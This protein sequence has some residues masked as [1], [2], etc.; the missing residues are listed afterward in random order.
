MP[1][2][3]LEALSVGLSAEIERCVSAADIETFAAVTG[4]TNPV[5][6]DEA[7]AATTV[8][9]GRVAH[10]MLVVGYLSAI[11]GTQLPGPGAIYISQTLRFRRPVRVGDK[12]IARVEITALDAAR[13]RATLATTCRVADRIVVDGEAVVMVAKRPTT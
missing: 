11:L 3:F 6:L 2:L 4:D 10:G 7:Y 5:H 1:G 8:F 12:V 9:G 13:A